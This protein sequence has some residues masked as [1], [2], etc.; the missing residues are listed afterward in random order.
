MNK[1]K[2]I[3]VCGSTRFKDY[4]LLV[5][6][7]QTLLDKIVL[8]PLVFAHSGDEISEEQKES[9]DELHFEKIKLSQEV[10]VVMYN[11]YVGD[12]T[13][14]EIEFSKSLNI[15]IIYHYFRDLRE[16]SS[17]ESCI[18]EVIEGEIK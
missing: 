15:P 12:S 4:I 6:K 18:V 7:N 3:T 9:L 10:H 14:R 11:G 13:R 8:L 17:A 1:N 5:A 16:D 2:I